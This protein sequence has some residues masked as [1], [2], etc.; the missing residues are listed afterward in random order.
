MVNDWREVPVPSNAKASLLIVHGA[1]E[2]YR[3]HLELA[4]TFA[5]AGYYVGMGDLPGY[6][7]ARGR[8]GHIEDFQEYVD[9]VR[10]WAKRLVKQCPGVPRFIFGHSLGGLITARFLE[11]QRGDMWDGVLLSSPCFGLTLAV[12][13]WKKGLARVLEH[14]WPT[15]RLKSGIDRDALCRNPEVRKLYQ[16]DPLVVKKVSVKWFWELQK[17][18][19][20]VHEE[21]D[22][23]RAPVLIVQGGEDRVVD[24]AATRRWY[25]RVPVE[26]K[27]LIWVDD[28]YHELLQ[29]FGKGEL[30]E[31]LVDWADSRIKNGTLTNKV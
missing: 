24:P 21:V 10:T 29:D 25:D 12:P 7:R 20:H 15:L 31:K 22:R 27:Q 3:R 2:H 8:R 6:G 11:Q 18:L 23:F 28:G 13:G 26:D 30:M 5:Q 16:A 19:T 4:H 9:T 14:V 1:G 17:A